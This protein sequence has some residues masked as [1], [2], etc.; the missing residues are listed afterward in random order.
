MC[1]LL[2]GWEKDDV[3][4]RTNETARLTS[5]LLVHMVMVA[6]THVDSRKSNN[7]LRMNMQA[8]GPLAAMRLSN[9]R[10]IER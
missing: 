8:G 7:L 10:K 1:G 3:V 6:R 5:R 4:E 2:S 9:V